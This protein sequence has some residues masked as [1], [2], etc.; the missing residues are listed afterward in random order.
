M[1]PIYTAPG[2]SR[3]TVTLMA[4]AATW[5]AF[6]RGPGNAVAGLIVRSLA[7]KPAPETIIRITLPEAHARRVVQ[8]A[9]VSS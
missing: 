8:L 3:E 1:M 9:E 6:I 2:D 4:T 7:G 5:E